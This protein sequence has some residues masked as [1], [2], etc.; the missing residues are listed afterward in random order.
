MGKWKSN[1]RDKAVE[2]EWKDGQ[3]HGK[4]VENNNFGNR[5]EY[6]VKEGK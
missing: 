4:A 1:Y 5:D 6:E 3:L 2:G